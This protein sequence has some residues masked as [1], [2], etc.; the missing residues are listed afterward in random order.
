[1]C[2][3]LPVEIADNRK[4][5]ERCFFYLNGYVPDVDGLSD[6]RLKVSILRKDLDNEEQ[7][8][9]AL[10]LDRFSHI[11]VRKDEKYGGP[12]RPGRVELIGDYMIYSMFFERHNYTIRAEAFLPDDRVLFS[13]EGPLLLLGEETVESQ[14]TDGLPWIRQ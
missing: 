12:L 11:V 14:D 1:M 13:F 7:F 3:R 4:R 2:L 6:A 5:D 8:V 9:L 10:P